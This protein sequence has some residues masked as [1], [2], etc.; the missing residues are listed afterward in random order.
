MNFNYRI[1]KN[2]LK[3]IYIKKYQKIN[4]FYII[5]STIIYFIVIKDTIKYNLFIYLIYYFFV[6]AVLLIILHF[7]NLIYTSLLIKL[8]IK[9]IIYDSDYKVEISNNKIISKNNNNKIIINFDDIDKIV[10]NKKEIIIKYNK[11]RI[12][13][14]SRSFLEN[15]EEFEKIIDYLNKYYIKKT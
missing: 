6:L 1:T 4:L 12:Y 8:N 13:L 2:D 3:K 11:N 10:Y 5:L 9:K 15:K 14:I 7:I